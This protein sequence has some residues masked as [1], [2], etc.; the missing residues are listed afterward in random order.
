MLSRL[1]RRWHGRRVQ[2]PAFAPLYADPPADEWVALDFETTSLDPAQAE[3]VA[4]GAVRIQGNRVLTGEA[5]SLRV[6]PPASLSEQSVTVHGLRHQDLRQGLALDGALRQLLAFIGSRELVGYHLA[7]D[8]RILNLACHKL[9]GLHLPQ[10]GIE[11]SRLYHDRLY[12]RYPD[13]V[14]DLHLAAISSHLGLPALPPHD[15]LADAVTAALIFLR[16]SQGGP[17]AYPKV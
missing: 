16:L 5:L 6:Q 3:I 15:A 8:L 14:I 10:R 1:R 13:A 9:W 2:D 17:L 7:Y 4:I 12:R 11:V